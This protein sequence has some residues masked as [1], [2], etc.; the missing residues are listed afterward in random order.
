MDA[1]RNRTWESEHGRGW[2]AET[3]NCTAYVPA[4]QFFSLNNFF[5]ILNNSTHSGFLKNVFL[6]QSKDSGDSSKI[7]SVETVSFFSRSCS[8]HHFHD[9]ALSEYNYQK[10]TFWRTLLKVQKI[11]PEQP[12]A[13]TIIHNVISYLHP[14]WTAGQVRINE[15]LWK[16]GNNH[17]HY[18][19]QAIC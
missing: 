15:R 4:Q 10:N 12:V 7:L 6:Q 19:R 13:K 9:I 1:T 14:T 18:H 16:C 5:F 17:S 8:I 3:R 2:D 11:D